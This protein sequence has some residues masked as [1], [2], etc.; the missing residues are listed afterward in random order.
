MYKGIQNVS[1]IKSTISPFR[2]QFYRPSFDINI[3][4]YFSN[5]KDAIARAKELQKKYPSDLRLGMDNPDNQLK[6]YL[7]KLR[8]GSTIN[9]TQLQ[10]TYYGSTS[11]NNNDVGR[12][13]EVLK[14]FEDRNFKILKDPRK[15]TVKKV[16]TPE[17]TTALNNKYSKEYGG[18]KGKELYN[19]LT[20]D[21]KRKLIGNFLLRARDPKTR[22]T[23]GQGGGSGARNIVI[24]QL[25]KL[26]NNK[27][28]KDFIKKVS[29]L[30]IRQR[31]DELEKISKKLSPIV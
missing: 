3:S 16:L 13:G 8:K 15:K 2:V 23:V 7:K 18:L 4:E 27:L 10:K 28:I 31:D 14:E 19:A 21:G 29:G 20:A 30:S 17:E 26:K 1:E 22:A 12:V 24:N 9:R 11:Q 5:E 6:E 25:K